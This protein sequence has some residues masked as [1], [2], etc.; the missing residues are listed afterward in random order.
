[1]SLTSD[2]FSVSDV[3]LMVN[4]WFLSHKELLVCSRLHMKPS[5]YLAIKGI[6]IK[7]ST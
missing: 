6:V 3:S 4:G 1:M 5:H 2:D 7:V